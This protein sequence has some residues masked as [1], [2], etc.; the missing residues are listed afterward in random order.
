MGKSIL[1]TVCL[2]LFFAC[3]ATTSEQPEKEKTAKSKAVVEE[4]A[5]VKGV[6]P[7]AADAITHSEAQAVDPTGKE[8]LNDAITC[9][10]R[11]IYWEARSSNAADMQAIANVVMNRLGHEGF[12]STICGIVKQGQEQHTC[13]F[14]WWCDGKPDSAQEE[15]PYAAAKEMARKALNH[16]LTDLTGGALYFHDNKSA[17]APAWSKKYIR[18]ATIA[19][20]VFYKP[21]GGKAK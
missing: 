19:H 2:I 15:E 6:D 20:H 1:V 7:P 5:T 21:I 14:S 12:P 13:Q 3:Q 4:K 11:T 8:G 18:T 17:P 10:A 16:E 9:L